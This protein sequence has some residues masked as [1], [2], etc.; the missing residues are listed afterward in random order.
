VLRLEETTRPTTGTDG[1]GRRFTV[2]AIG[3]RVSV[4][5][6]G[7]TIVSASMAAGD[8]L[9][10]PLA[11]EQGAS[12]DS[13]KSSKASSD[14]AAE[15]DLEVVVPARTFTNSLYQPNLEAIEERRRSPRSGSLSSGLSGK[16]S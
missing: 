11:V 8:S 3:S 14:T 15:D 16:S 7:S 1:N 10:V 13:R 5:H 2:T 6:R 4:D 12:A 9:A